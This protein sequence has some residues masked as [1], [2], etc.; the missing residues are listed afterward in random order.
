M[1][2]HIVPTFTDPG[3]LGDRIGA[4]EFMCAGRR[5]LRSSS[6]LSRHGREQKSS[7]P[8]TARRSIVT[9]QRSICTFGG[10]RNARCR[11]RRRLN[12]RAIG[13]CRVACH[14]RRRLALPVADGRADCWH[15][16][17]MRATVFEQTAN[18]KNGPGSAFAEC[19]PW[20]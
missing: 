13:A 7:G 17:G 9:T 10:R 5:R 20:Y 15:A 16:A 6:R 8:V 3:R 18:S 14:R 4:T 11:F 2:E 19:Q 1:A 12:V